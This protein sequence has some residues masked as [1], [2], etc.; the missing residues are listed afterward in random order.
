MRDDPKKGGET[1]TEGTWSHRLP[2]PVAKRLVTLRDVTV[3]VRDRHI[4][5]NTSWE[6]RTG[7]NWAVLGPNGSGKSSLVRLL[8]NDIPYSRG[9]IVFHGLERRRIGYVS[10]ELHE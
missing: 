8:V 9:E 3:R 5:P 7:Q 10:L 6:I 2:G 1:R 4:L